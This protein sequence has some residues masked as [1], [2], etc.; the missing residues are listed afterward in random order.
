MSPL[1]EQSLQAEKWSARHWGTAVWCVAVSCGASS[2]LME[3]LVLKA[4]R[5]LTEGE[6]ADLLLC[7]V[8]S[9]RMYAACNPPTLPTLKI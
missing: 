4:A 6:Y 1:E 5:A 7:P 3:P 2:P 8:P 9:V